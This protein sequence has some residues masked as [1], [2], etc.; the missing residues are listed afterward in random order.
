MSGSSVNGDMVMVRGFTCNRSSKSLAA[1]F[2]SSET[3]DRN[4]LIVSRPN[5]GICRKLNEDEQ[6]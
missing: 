6:R 1:I 4:F 3:F 5:V 2:F